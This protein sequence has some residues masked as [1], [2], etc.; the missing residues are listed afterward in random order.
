MNNENSRNVRQRV[1]NADSLQNLN[2]LY[3][4]TSRQE[5]PTADLVE[6]FEEYKKAGPTVDNPSSRVSTELVEKIINTIKNSTLI[7]YDHRFEDG[8]TFLMEAIYEDE[9]GIAEALID[10]GYGLL[11]ATNENNST[12]LIMSLGH[13]YP[14][15]A[16]KIIDS[17]NGNIDQ[18]R[19]EDNIT[20]LLEAIEAGYFDIAIKLLD[21]GMQ[22]IGVANSYGYTALMYACDTDNSPDELI[23]KLIDSGK[24]NPL[25]ISDTGYTALMF[26][27]VTKRSEIALKLI[28]TGQSNP[29]VVNSN[30]LTALMIACKEKMYEVASKLVDLGHMS[31]MFA[32][33]NGYGAEDY[34]LQNKWNE[35]H[36]KMVAFLSSPM[37]VDISQKGTNIFDDEDNNKTIS[38][39][40]SENR[41]NICFILNNNVYYSSSD[42]VRTQL[43]NPANIKYRCFTCGYTKFTEQ[44]EINSFDFM[45]DSNIDNSFPYF[46]MSSVIPHKILVSELM[47]NQALSFYSSN[48]FTLQD[49]GITLPGI[50]SKDYE[51]GNTSADHCQSDGPMK[52]YYLFVSSPYCSTTNT[53]S[54]NDSMQEEED[55]SNVVYIKYKNVDY[56]FTIDKSTNIG[57]LKQI[58]LRDLLDKGII[59]GT[60]SVRFIFGGKILSNDSQ[61]ISSLGSLPITIQSLIT[62]TNVGGKKNTKKCKNAF[63]KRFTKRRVKKFTKKRQRY[64]KRLC[65]KTKH[66]RR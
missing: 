42:I 43:D 21:A 22:N 23:Y 29:G 47:L 54:Q 64:S 38:E 46:S 16:N 34:A 60:G 11:D 26:S 6:L 25:A 17:N 8:N 51:Y 45:E 14:H 56:P 66:R 39:Y 1:S 57:S 15:I 40:L 58:L 27:I 12:A 61:L 7:N 3:I 36:Q 10:S 37:K 35:L 2:S 9:E 65:K 52:V 33:N 31:N 32:K 5:R 50:M 48:I 63:K 13:H 28:E 41:D 55:L 18:I 30:E 62:L 4:N 49:I 59:P 19:N 20:A 44:G 53:D 24:S